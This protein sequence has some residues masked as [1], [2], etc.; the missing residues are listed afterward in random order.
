MPINLFD[1]L[2][3]VV[4]IAGAVRGRAHGISQELVAVI[5]WLCMVLGCAV[6]YRP[7]GIIL[8]QL[9]LLDLLAGYLL[10]YTV[11]ALVLFFLFSRFQRK[12]SPKL[13]GTDAF[14]RGEYYLGLGSGLV[15]FACVTIMALAL[16]NARAFTPG[17]L[18]AMEKYQEQTYG[19]VFFPNLHTLQAAVFEQSLTG[20]WIRQ[21]LQFLLITPTQAGQTD[22][23]ASSTHLSAR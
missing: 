17:E 16:L 21:G 8:A 11:S 12:L 20:P 2:L 5:K 14:G 3:V 18:K 22:P 6:L 4:L 7:A 10:A 23:S 9:G 19:S 13:T 1:C 15:R